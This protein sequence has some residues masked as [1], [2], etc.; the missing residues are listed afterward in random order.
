MPKVFFVSIILALF[1]QIVHPFNIGMLLVQPL[2]QA[3]NDF[4]F[5]IDALRQAAVPTSLGATAA[6]TISETVAGAI[7]GVAS[8]GTAKV[9][10][11]AKKDSLI[12]KVQTTSVYFLSRTIFLRTSMVL[13][14]PRPL[15]RVTSTLLASIVSEQTKAKGRSEKDSEKLEIPEIVND[16]TKWLAFDALESMG[17]FHFTNDP[18]HT[19]SI[20]FLYGAISAFLGSITRDVYM[21][22]GKNQQTRRQFLGGKQPGDHSTYL[23]AVIEGAMLFGC[24][25]TIMEILQVA[26]P[27]SL[28]TKFLFDQVL[29]T[30][31]ADI[32]AAELMIKEEIQRF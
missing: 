4:V 11:D 6:I 9:I 2:D 24:Y 23:Q 12:T 28:T 20:A 10:G 5:A 14:F 31:E 22:V 26:F 29:E 3:S 7:G 8:R 32:Q 17:P 25:Q 21:T 16:V 27:Q 15:A 19:I 30:M 18:L 13:G 1:M